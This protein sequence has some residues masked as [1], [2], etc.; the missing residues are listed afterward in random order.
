MNAR[1]ARAELTARLDEL[2]ASVPAAALPFGSEVSIWQSA[3]DGGLKWA[4][5]SPME[6]RR[7]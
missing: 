5:A 6:P 4:M 1:Q 2:V 7:K 3:N